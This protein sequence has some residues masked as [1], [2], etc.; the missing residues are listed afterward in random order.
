MAA[1]LNSMHISS[2]YTSH[3]L[4]SDEMMDVGMDIPSTSTI[5]V[6]EKLKGHTIVLSEEV[7]KIT[8]EPL[9]PPSIVERY[10]LRN[11]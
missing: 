6:H 4:A 7:K 3:S 2:E 10:V 9:L 11:V 8:E 1:H 5:N